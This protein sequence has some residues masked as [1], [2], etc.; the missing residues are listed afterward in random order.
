[1]TFLPE[2]EPRAARPLPVPVAYLLACAPGTTLLW[3]WEVVTLRG[4]FASWGW[5]I[6]G[7]LLY[8]YVCVLIAAGFFSFLIL[9][10]SQHL[11]RPPLR[12]WI[13]IA[14]GA[15]C[16]FLVAVLLIWAIKPAEPVPLVETLSDMAANVLAG[17]VTGGLLQAVLS[18]GRP[19][20]T[21]S[22]RRAS[23]DA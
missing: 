14:Y 18:R 8:E 23:S 4:S 2:R 17:G 16:G 9:L 19:P 11:R 5:M 12:V 13:A 22:R 15:V 7:G 21:P 6:V 3:A 10:T 20:Q 1:M